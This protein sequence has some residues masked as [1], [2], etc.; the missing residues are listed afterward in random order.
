MFKVFTQSDK[1]YV[2]FYIFRKL[3]RS[4]LWYSMRVLLFLLV[5]GIRDPKRL[6]IFEPNY[7]LGVFLFMAFYQLLSADFNL[8]H[9]RLCGGEDDYSF[10]NDDYGPSRSHAEFS[11]ILW[12]S[13]LRTFFPSS[14]NMLDAFFLCCKEKLMLF[15]VTEFES[16]EKFCYLSFFCYRIKNSKDSIDKT[17]E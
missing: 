8:I 1:K 12:T 16:D 3:F 14:Y 13:T 9:Q 6:L 17:E 5:L 10:M 7:W 4:Q 11:A 15:H 2:T